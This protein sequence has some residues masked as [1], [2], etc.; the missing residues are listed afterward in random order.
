VDQSGRSDR[1]LVDGAIEGGCVGAGGPGRPAQLA[2][3]LERGGADFV[4]GCGRL[5]VGEGLDVSAHV[6]APWAVK[7]VRFCAHES[8]R[9]RIRRALGRATPSVAICIGR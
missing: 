8:F 5:E 2:D 1:H 3:E 9:T 7:K 4:F 6:D